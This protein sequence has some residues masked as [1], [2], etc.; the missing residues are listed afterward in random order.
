MLP[1]V[2]L[3]V[4]VGIGAAALAVGALVAGLLAY[5]AGIRHRQKVAEA[6]IGSAEKEAERILGDAK[7]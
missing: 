4:A 3:L 6:Q 2:S 5:K 1:E 7:Q